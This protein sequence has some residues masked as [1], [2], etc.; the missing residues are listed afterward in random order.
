MTKIRI[1]NTIT[2]GTAR[3]SLIEKQIG[4]NQPTKSHIQDTL[5]SAGKGLSY[6]LSLS[7]LSKI[8]TFVANTYIIRQLDPGTKGF[9]FK[10]ELFATTVIFLSSECFRRACLRTN[11]NES[12][13]ENQYQKIRTISLLSIPYGLLTMIFCYFIWGTF[14]LPK[15]DSTISP[16]LIYSFA[17]FIEIFAQPMYILSLAQLAFGVRVTIEASALFIKIISSFFIVNICKTENV[18]LYFGYS[19]I[20]YSLT[21]FIGYLIYNF[22]WNNGNKL[23]EKFTISWDWN[24]FELSQSFLYQSVIKYILTEGEKHILILFR[25]QYDQGVYDIVFN[26]GSLAARLIFQYLEE[27]SFSIWSKLSNIVNCT[28]RKPSNDEITESVTTSATVLILFLKA[29][30]LIGCVFAFFGPAYSHTL[31]YLLYGDQWANNTEA[32]QILSIYCFYI[33]FMALNGIS[34]AFIHALSDRKEIIKLN[35]IMILFSIVYM[36]VCITC[37]WLFNLGT[38]SMIIANCFNMLM[39]ISYSTYF[40]VLFFKKHKNNL[41]MKP[42]EILQQIIPSKVVLIVLSSCLVITKATELYFD[43]SKTKLFCI[44]RFVHI[45]VGSLFL[46]LFIVCLYK[47]EK[48]FIRQFTMF[49]R[50]EIGTTLNEK[51]E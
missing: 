37:L 46:M 27:T 1:S 40:I 12:N 20:C 34:E 19:Q 2:D 17:T 16:L 43:I 13:N 44:V 31:I 28:E 8:V 11:L 45:G 41:R 29:S 6:L 10:S 36:S 30:I 4:N 7:F 39:R 22:K 33:F 47:F 38:K 51:Q 5:T 26:L 35:Y 18:L 49:R 25:T 9:I 3:E 42:S 15:V 24:L 21:I 23:L 32:P 14:Y 50:G 48:P